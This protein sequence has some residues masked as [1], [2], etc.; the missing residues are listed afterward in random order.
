MQWLELSNLFFLYMIPA[1]LLFYLLKKKYE[2][3]QISSILL[4][5]KM[6]R[7]IDAHKPWQKLR[8]NIL[9]IL[10][11]LIAILL[12]IALL[13]PVTL[14]EGTTIANHTVIVVDT[15]GSM[16]TNE[17]NSTRFELAKERIGKTIGTLG[18]NQSI[19]LIEMGR[20]PR[21]LVAKSSNK[22][23]LNEALNSLEAREGIGDDYAAFSLA[24]SIA[25]S[26]PNSGIMWFG[27]GANYKLNQKEE[28]L[29]EN[30]PFEHVQVGSTKENVLI[31]SFIT[32]KTT[33]GNEGIITIDN[34][35]AET[36]TINLSLYDYAN[37]PITSYQF[38]LAGNSSKTVEI[39]LLP[40]SDAYLAK[41][42]TVNDGL[43][44]DNTLWSVPF[45][46][47]EMQTVFVSEN[48]NHF[49]SQ[50][51][52]AGQDIKIDKIN[53]Y[54]VSSEKQADIWIF[55]RIVPER[56][57]EGNILL[58]GPNSS[59]EWVTLFGE[60]DLEYKSEV[61]QPEHEIL[62]HVN[63]DKVH[64][65]KTQQLGEIEGLETLIK[66]GDDPILL[67]G[68][69]DGKRIVILAFDIY[70]SDLPL[71]IAFPILIQNSLT[72]LSPEKSLPIGIA[73]SGETTNIPFSPGSEN[74][75][76]ITPS[77]Q[78]KPIESSEAVFQYMLPEET[79]LYALEETRD[80]KTVTRLFS[81]KMNEDESKI[82][83]EPLKVRY[84]Y[85]VNEEENEEIKTF[86]YKELSKWFILL[87]LLFSFIEWVV[88]TRG[89]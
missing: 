65:A 88:Y 70:D 33:D 79:G 59:T 53:K 5:N 76:L 9:L 42:D 44:N 58:I 69:L 68:E 8:R 75:T 82:K 26:E 61:V 15:S 83:P 52:G 25:L 41:I 27:D 6:I 50:A 55:D 23:E 4:W 80:T 85:N 24:R 89:Y 84:N 57:P 16:L 14:T 73:Y 64:I 11:L 62:K 37:T 36:K 38:Q 40:Q 45:N 43:A 35:G 78:R 31:S 12:L 86:G 28:A 60:K 13:R 3:R 18:K 7:D 47:S 20:T 87:A 77:N 81:V 39:P 48:G 71:Q 30:I 21:V 29:P 34:F 1:I 63:W 17:G 19:T 10:Q 67:A 66:A 22:S 2:D 72:W 56:L 46:Q 32:Q 74:K 54:P 51:L 49:I